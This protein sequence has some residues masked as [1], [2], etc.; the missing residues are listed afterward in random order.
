MS[1]T[2]RLTHAEANPCG[3]RVR[4]GPQ[5][6]PVIRCFSPSSSAKACWSHVPGSLTSSRVFKVAHGGWTGAAG[7]PHV[8]EGKTEPTSAGLVSTGLRAMLFCS[9]YARHR[10]RHG[11]RHTAARAGRR[12]R[13]VCR[14]RPFTTHADRLRP[15]LKG[16]RL[17]GRGGAGRGRCTT[18]PFC[19][20]SGSATSDT[21]MNAFRARHVWPLR[22]VRR[23]KE[24]EP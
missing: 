23:A 4:N 19:N 15:R 13:P 18:V 3:Q 16:G 2:R 9:T 1:A 11:I 21:P 5:R 22:H 14:K 7:P 17:P 10:I 8:A 6:L 12:P 20:M 24:E